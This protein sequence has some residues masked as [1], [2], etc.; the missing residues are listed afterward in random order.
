MDALY[1][2]LDSLL[3]LMIALWST[4]YSLAVLVLQYA[5]LIAW[6]AFWLLADNWE[7]YRHVLANGGWIGLILIGFVMVLVLLEPNYS[8]KYCF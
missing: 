4:F 6:V 2:L 8:C 3:Q 1:Q 7:K 5:P